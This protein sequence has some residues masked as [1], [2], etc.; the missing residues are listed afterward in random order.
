MGAKPTT[1]SPR[2]P[3]AERPVADRLRQALA[4]M[5][6]QQGLGSEPRALTATTLCQLAAVSRNA[7]YRYHPDVLHALRKIQRE[8]RCAPDP[9]RRVVQQVRGEN[10]ALREQVT[11]LAALVDHYY[12]AWMENRTLLERREREL[13][14]L[15][16][17][18]K[19]RVTPI[20]N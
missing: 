16:R 6:R 5:V 17:N 7:L 11:R 9:A 2:Q 13:A 4:E 1:D 15:R 20:R 3:P 12:A 8:Y 14:E 10:D 18:I 19:P